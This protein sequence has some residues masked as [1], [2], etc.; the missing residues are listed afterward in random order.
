MALELFNRVRGKVAEYEYE[1]LFK[2][3]PQHPQSEEDQL[4]LSVVTMPYSLKILAGWPSRYPLYPITTRLTDVTPPSRR[5]PSQTTLLAAIE[6]GS[7]VD[8]AYLQIY[9]PRVALLYD[10]KR[11]PPIPL[12]LFKDIN[13]L[14]WQGHR[15]QLCESWIPIS[16]LVFPSLRDL[17]LSCEISLQ[18]C[19]YIL[20]HFDR[21]W[22]LSVDAIEKELSREPRFPSLHRTTH[23]DRPELHSLALGS[24]DDIGPLFQQ[25]TFP[26]LQNIVLN[27]RYPTIGTFDGLD[28]WPNIQTGRV[29]GYATK[30]DV[31]WIRN[32]L[33]PQSPFETP[34]RGYL[35]RGDY[36]SDEEDPSRTKKFFKRYVEPSSIINQAEGTEY[37]IPDFGRIQGKVLEHGRTRVFLPGLPFVAAIGLAATLTAAYC[38]FQLYH[39]S[40]TQKTKPIIPPGADRGEP[41]E[42]DFVVQSNPS[43]K[44][45]TGEA[46][47]GNLV[48]SSKRPQVMM[49]LGE[50]NDINLALQS[51]PDDATLAKHDECQ[52]K[53][54]SR[55]TIPL[56]VH[57]V[58][59][60][61]SE[62]VDWNAENLFKFGEKLYT[63]DSKITFASDSTANLVVQLRRE[64]PVIPTRNNPG[65][66]FY[67]EGV[68]T[69][70]WES[71]RNQLPLMYNSA[72]TIHPTDRLTSLTL[73][74]EITERDCAFFLYE[75]KASL[76]H[77]HVNYILGSMEKEE[78]LEQIPEI[79]LEDNHEVWRNLDSNDRSEMTKL[80][81]LRL[82]SRELDLCNLVN[83]FKFPAL[84][85]FWILPP[86][87][88]R[89]RHPSYVREQLML[90]W[91]NIPDDQ[92]NVQPRVPGA[93]Q[94]AYR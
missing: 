21:L 87:K 29:D 66:L 43:D 94:R 25:F 85:Q 80:K 82:H 9:L 91:N 13:K 1:W 36:D 27:L 10:G 86:N 56:S 88:T 65:I 14:K 69:V 46:N 4:E 11:E 30:E 57:T 3:T 32:S 26:S 83:R 24:D 71:H 49:T 78:Q 28:I 15:D 74:C 70:T 76:V 40:K 77:F 2:E 12:D 42:N 60:S 47:D 8:L 31:E 18:D 35:F 72:L 5:L 53:L 89:H 19:A 84:T 90:P 45:P 17:H 58:R 63:L 51:D 75:F 79:T 37:K 52:K 41:N 81:S 93:R 7:F 44:I 34:T 68:R 67:L 54:F 59:M 50:S 23:I 20:F 61:V 39:L 48:R 6:K 16:P 33:P 73:L 55:S 22:G 62:S 64:F 92:T 38:A